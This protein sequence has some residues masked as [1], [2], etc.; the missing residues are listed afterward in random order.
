MNTYNHLYRTKKQFEAFLKGIG[1]DLTMRIL[2]RIHSCIHSAEKIS[3]LASEIK[4]VLPEANIVGC[5]TAGV[6]CDGKILSDACLVSISTFETGEIETFSTDCLDESRKNK[7][8]DTLCNELSKNLIRGRKGFLLIFLPPLFRKSISFVEEMNFSNPQVQILGGGA[9]TING[10][11]TESRYRAYVMDGTKTSNTGLAAAFITSEKMHIYENYI[12]GVESVGKNYTVTKTGNHCLG[13]VDG[14]DGA[15]WYADLLG[16]TELDKNPQLSNLFPVVKETD[17]RTPFYVDYDPDNGGK[18]KTFTEFPKGTSVSL[19]YFN[20]QKMQE[21]MRS[22][23]KEFKKHPIQAIFAYDC[24][25][26]VDLLRNCAK[27]EVGQFYTTNISG[28]LLSGEIVYYKG[29]NRYVNF[30]FVMACLAE[31]EKSHVY[32]RSRELRNI[33]ALQQDNMHIVNYLLA[34]GNRQLNK[35]LKNQQDKIKKSMFHNE[36]LGLDNQLGY[37]Y[38][39]E[40]LGYDKIALFTLT[41]E[42]MVK[43]FVG[44][45]NLFEELKTLFTQLRSILSENGDVIRIYSIDTASL[46]LAADD[47]IDITDFENKAEAI[48]DYLNGRTLSQM[49]LSYH[50]AIVGNEQEPLH[51]AETAIQYGIEHNLAFINYDKILREIPDVTEEVHLLQVIRDALAE[52]GVIPYFQGIIDNH[53]RKICLYESLIRIQDKDGKI[54]Y[55]D[56]FMPI[57][58]ENNLYEPLSVIMIKKVMEMFLDKDICVSINL[59]IRDIYDREVIKIIFDSLNIAQ[60]PENFIFELVEA[61]KITDYDYVEAFASRIHSYGAKIAID[62]FGTGFSNLMHI[63]RIDADYIK[64]DGEIIR[65]VCQDEKCKEFINVINYWCKN[66]NK[67][68][69]AEFVES[70]ESQQALEKMGVEYSQG[71]FFSKPAPWEEIFQ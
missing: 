26:R 51:K 56:R 44:R 57:A 18:L 50:C 19:G 48:L 29:K 14:I 69:I 54:Y 43:L 41:N 49:N 60:K 42:R 59:N 35:Q 1:I 9:G 2:I 33:T 4:N 46:L 7:S 40:N 28:A 52:D 68:M 63:I 25:S 16:K 27:W 71:Y 47:R 11:G 20:P 23:Y 67:K 21:E 58:K 15:E 31:G 37:L 12:C 53:S 6:I 36:A 45:K 62:D 39:R 65:L 13:Q 24:Q 22:V 34:S 70:E 55:P 32:L 10:Y 66:N 64:I 30:T 8:G 61:E 17:I 5:S 3:T 38:D